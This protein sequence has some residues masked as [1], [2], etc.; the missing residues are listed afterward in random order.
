MVPF[1]FK[2][3]LSDSYSAAKVTSAY[4]WKSMGDLFA[5]I[6]LEHCIFFVILSGILQPYPKHLLCV[7]LL[8]CPLLAQLLELRFMYKFFVVV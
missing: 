1:Y 8:N 2:I 4:C 6:L 5:N 3:L 7:E